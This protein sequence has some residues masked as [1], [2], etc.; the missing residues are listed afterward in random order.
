MLNKCILFKCSRIASSGNQ[1]IKKE[2][3][4]DSND[5]DEDGDTIYRP[6]KKCD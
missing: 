5:S 6:D 4:R 2:S 1:C 3:D